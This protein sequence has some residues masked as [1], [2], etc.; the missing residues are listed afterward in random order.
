MNKKGNE[1]GYIVFNGWNIIVCAKSVQ[2]SNTQNRNVLRTDDKNPTRA[3]THPYRSMVYG[4]GNGWN[5]SRKVEKRRITSVHTPI[6]RM[7][8]C[9]LKLCTQSTTT[10]IP[11]RSSG[12]AW[13]WISS[14]V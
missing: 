12:S 6:A 8:P 13:Y 11:N 1:M 10:H 14:C 2:I 5:D 4:V 3:T 7:L 9:V